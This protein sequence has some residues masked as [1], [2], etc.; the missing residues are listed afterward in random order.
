MTREGR[1]RGRIPP[2]AVILLLV[3][4]FAGAPPGEGL[5]GTPAADS[6]STQPPSRSPDAPLRPAA[7]IKDP[8]L[9][10]LIGIFEDDR[11]GFFP[12]ERILAELSRLGRDTRIPLTSFGGLTR[13]Q[14]PGR[15][16][17]IALGAVFRGDG[18]IP[19]PYRILTYRPGR[20]RASPVLRLR[21]WR[22]GEVRFAP[23]NSEGADGVVALRDA[24]V[25]GITDGS[26]MLDVDGWLDALLG[27]RLDDTRIVGFAVFRHG[28]RRIGMAMGYNREGR[29]HSGAF[30]LEEDRILFPTPPELQAAA[31]LLRHRVERLLA[32]E[33]RAGRE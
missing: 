26:F 21:E 9:A 10:I 29:G 25:W 32:E 11:R 5:A 12:R 4:L 24:T 23:G 3:I 2:R 7:G 33:R 6:S 30:L 18:E 15:P 19:I 27:A 17:A 20:L 13:A 8:A 22:L 14:L 16:D 28:G 1:R 31:R